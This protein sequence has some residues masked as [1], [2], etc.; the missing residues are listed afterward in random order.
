[1][2]ESV[3]PDLMVCCALTCADA[4]GLPV[5]TL[6]VVAD[7]HEAAGSGLVC[8]DLH[9]VAVG[10]AVVHY[11][12]GEPQPIPEQLDVLKPKPRW[13]VHLPDAGNRAG[14]FA[15][16][17]RLLIA[18]PS[19][20]AASPRL[21]GWPAR[22]GIC[23]PSPA[24]SPCSPAQ[25]ASGLLSCPAPDGLIGVEVRAVP[26]QVYQPKPQARRPEVLPHRLPTV[27]LTRVCISF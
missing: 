18:G 10:T 25:I 12:P 17:F 14:R 9:V 5:E 1:M 23:R 7:V 16:G 24:P 3:S 27:G 2:L 22:T 20:S 19:G 26:R 4:T 21:S 15:G 8:E 6:Y 11:E 13:D